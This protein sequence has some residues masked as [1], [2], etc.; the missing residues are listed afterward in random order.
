[1]DAEDDLSFGA[2]SI[3]SDDARSRL[4]EA[5]R[6]WEPPEVLQE[7]LREDPTQATTVDRWGR[8]PAHVV[9][10]NRSDDLGI[11]RRVFDAYPEAL[12]VP[13]NGGYLPLHLAAAS[14]AT[15]FEVLQ[16]IVDA[17][18][19]ALGLPTNCGLLPLHCAATNNKMPLEMVEFLVHRC[20]ASLTVKD[21]RGR[22]P[23]H[24]V[25]AC[26]RPDVFRFFAEACPDALA[27]ADND[28][29]LPRRPPA[30]EGG[31]GPGTDDN[32]S[33]D[34][35]RPE[36]RLHRAISEM[37]P[38][39]AIQEILRTDP[40]SI[41]AKDSSGQL[42][43]HEAAWYRRTELKIV[44]CVVE[45]FEEAL[46]VQDDRR[47]L[48]IHCA[49]DQLTTEPVVDVVQWLVQK[50]PEALEVEDDLGE[51]P[52][53][54]ATSIFNNCRFDVAE[55][56]VHGNPAA[57][58]RAF[59]SV[60]SSRSRTVELVQCLVGAVPDTLAVPDNLGRLPLHCA[61]GSTEFQLEVVQILVDALPEAL[62][63]ADSKGRLPL[64]C[65]ADSW[66]VEDVVQY[67][68]DAHPEAL[69]VADNEGML[70][71]HVAAAAD[72]A[73]EVIE[74]LVS[75]RPESLRALDNC[76]RLPLHVAENGLV[77]YLSGAHPAAL[78]A[79]DNDGCLPLH[80]AAAKG[81]SLENVELLA[82]VFPA[83]L[84]AKDGKG[85]LPL[86]HA[87]SRG[88]LTPVRFLADSH[89]A[90]L[91]VR[92]SDGNL[93]L[94]TAA[95]E[96]APVEVVL[97]L[98]R[99]CPKALEEKTNSGSTPL[100][101]AARYSRADVVQC[102]VDLNQFALR[103][104]DCNGL[105]PIHVAA[106]RGTLDVVQR[107]VRTDFEALLKCTR[108]LQ[109]DAGQYLQLGADVPVEEN[110][111]LPVQLAAMNAKTLDTVYYLL[112]ACPAA[113]E[114]GTRSSPGV[115][116]SHNSYD[117]LSPA[118]HPCGS[119]IPCRGRGCGKRTREDVG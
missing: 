71:L 58:R 74:C 63:T 19:E 1:M 12:L 22:T 6:D 80:A 39:E 59:H 97:F 83:A 37:V 84:H 45:A 116:R 67:L 113:L 98:A 31:E 103:T 114:R 70:P 85:R 102:L 109:A 23:L 13:D 3:E 52:L 51:L 33:Q 10:K 99:K 50:R 75:R 90:G 21:E 2:S 92:D 34:E 86:H 89:P 26:F 93:P 48:P 104:R 119:K 110:G 65:A 42:P 108:R 28:G 29:R 43:A 77:R 66:S 9:A 60:I 95:A 57:S 27:V 100:H 47:R 5:I 49:V 81:L 35:S 96:Q 40:N 87:A 16:W 8:L 78:A 56:L 32:R 76:G 54:A 36:C 41:K 18:P 17:H 91:L 38:L 112:K 105:L 44:Q 14:G 101:V 111:W 79:V 94:H 82:S 11:V 20:P 73:V 30:T 68:A 88:S 15:S 24:R 72:A 117:L 46:L 55:C 107:L 61:F 25:D 64:H 4:H 115:A 69:A 53:Q 62:A 118:K 7:I 106:V